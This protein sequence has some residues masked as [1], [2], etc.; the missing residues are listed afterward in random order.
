MCK[1]IRL[2]PI[3]NRMRFILTWLC[4]TNG[5]RK[6]VDLHPGMQPS[7]L[8]KLQPAYD[9]V[10]QLP[11]LEAYLDFLKHPPRN[12]SS[13]EFSPPAIVA[14]YKA[15]SLPRIQSATSPDSTS[16][17]LVAFETW[18][19]DGLDNWLRDNLHGDDTCAELSTAIRTYHRF[20]TNYY[21]GNPEGWTA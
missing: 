2:N 19:A 15:G 14:S 8:E 12:N 18:V 9:I 13:R 5:Q 11:H 21:R 7:R 6:S 10:T 1:C 20:A 16:F 17:M 4:S 3:T